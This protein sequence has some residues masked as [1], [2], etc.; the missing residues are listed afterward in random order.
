MPGLSTGR[1][2]TWTMSAPADSVAS[3]VKPCSL[4]HVLMSGT[5]NA[6]GLYW[7][8]KIAF[9]PSFNAPTAEPIPI[10]R[11]MWTLLNPT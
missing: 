8:G 2:L 3:L 5:I 7:K 11:Q 4:L 6:Y 10:S 9:I 1:F